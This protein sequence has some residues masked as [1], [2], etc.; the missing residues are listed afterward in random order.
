VLETLTGQDA[1]DIWVERW[2]EA[3]INPPTS[4]HRVLVAV[5]D[6]V[7]GGASGPS[8]VVVGFASAG[9]ATDADRWPGT[10]AELYELRVRPERTG[11]GH[12]SR[13]LHAVAETLADDGFRTACTWALEVDAALRRFLESSGWAAD[14]ARAELEVG[15]LVP[16]IRLHTAIAD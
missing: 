11:H 16:A 9:P 15:V 8:R 7:E 4:R 1:F 10:D 13:L 12:G 5:E 2:R 14:G 6:A 3:I